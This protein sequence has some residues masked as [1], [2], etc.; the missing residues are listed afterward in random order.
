MKT[1]FSEKSLSL[2]TRNSTCNALGSNSDLRDVIVLYKLFVPDFEMLTDCDSVWS[3]CT[4]AHVCPAIV[5]LIRIGYNTVKIVYPKSSGLCIIVG[6][7][8]TWK[9]FMVI[10]KYFQECNERHMGRHWGDYLDVKSRNENN[11]KIDS[12]EMNCDDLNLIRLDYGR[13]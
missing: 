13:Y 9:R 12:Q 1:N 5:K 10:N 7:L 4:C 2:Y 8:C 3:V 11:I 6:L